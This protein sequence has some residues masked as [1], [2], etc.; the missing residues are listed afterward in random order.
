MFRCVIAALWSD[1]GETASRMTLDFSA[2][3]IG[4]IRNESS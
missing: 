3:E 4:E 1:S 2:G